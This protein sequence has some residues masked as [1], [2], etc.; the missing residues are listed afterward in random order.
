MNRR[1]LRRLA[2]WGRFFLALFEDLALGA[3]IAIAAL[4][5][6]RPLQLKLVNLAAAAGRVWR[7]AN[8]PDSASHPAFVLS[9]AKKG[10]RP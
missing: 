4:L 9:P 1:R 6:T 10:T 2:R 8:P 5:N 7:R 3:D